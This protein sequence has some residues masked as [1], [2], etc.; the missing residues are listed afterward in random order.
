MQLSLDVQQSGQLNTNVQSTSQIFCFFSS[1]YFI[2]ASYFVLFYC[3]KS[4][5]N[6]LNVAVTL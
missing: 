4:K 1:F 3:I 5:G 6:A 2:F